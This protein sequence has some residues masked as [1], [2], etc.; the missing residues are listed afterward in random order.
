M[1]H[2]MDRKSCILDATSRVIYA[3][4]LA[5]IYWDRFYSMSHPERLRDLAR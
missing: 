3:Y 2:H 1:S 5:F 4:L